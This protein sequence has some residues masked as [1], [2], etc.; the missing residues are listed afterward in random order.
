MPPK[1]E[2]LGRI[3]K[4]VADVDSS[5]GPVFPF[6]GAEISLIDGIDSDVECVF[7]GDFRHLDTWFRRGMGDAFSREEKP[8]Q[9]KWSERFTARLRT[10]S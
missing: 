7:D 5:A 10:D 9:R 4:N 2:V 6:F 1:I 3:G 8:T